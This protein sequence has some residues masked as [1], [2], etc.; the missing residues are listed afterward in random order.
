LKL[1]TSVV[2]A[3][4]IEESGR[5]LVTRRQAGVHL[6]GYWEFPGGKC[7]PG[8]S[9]Q[10]C[11][12]REMQEELAVGVQVT[13]KILETRHPY[14]DRIIELH[15]YVCVLEGEPRPLLGQDMRWVSRGEL[16]SLPF[17][18]ADAELIARLAG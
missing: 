2:V 18:P 12:Q 16:A 4:V 3:A 5:F 11:L 10:A 9:H 6:E 15:F 8:E 7:D 17:P 14:P 13:G 1:E